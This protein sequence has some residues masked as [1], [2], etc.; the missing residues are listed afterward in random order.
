[1]AANDAERD[2]D[3]QCGE[4][5]EQGTPGLVAVAEGDPDE[6]S[7]GAFGGAQ[8]GALELVTALGDEDGAGIAIMAGGPVGGGELLVGLGAVTG[9]V[10]AQQRQPAPQ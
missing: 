6:A 2:G 7:P 8:S 3:R 9:R 1:M 10:L 4:E 5:Q